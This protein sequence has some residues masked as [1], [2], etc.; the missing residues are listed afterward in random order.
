MP[1]SLL[2]LQA[3][4]SGTRRV[5]PVAQQSWP[6]KTQSL[7]LHPVPAARPGCRSPPGPGVSICETV[8]PDCGHTP[9]PQLRHEH[10]R[11]RQRVPPETRLFSLCLLSRGLRSG[12]KKR[13]RARCAAP[14]PGP[15][16][17]R[18]RL[19]PCSA[20]AAACR[21]G[22]G[23]SA[24]PDRPS[25]SFG[26]FWGGRR[27][28]E[29]LTKSTCPCPRAGTGLAPAG[30]VPAHRPRPRPPLGHREFLSPALCLLRVA[31][32][33]L[34]RTTSHPE[35]WRAETLTPPLRQRA[36]ALCLCS[37]RASTD[38][39]LSL[40]GQRDA[41]GPGKSPARSLTHSLAGLPPGPSDSPTRAPPKSLGP[42]LQKCLS[43]CFH[44]P[45]PSSTP[46]PWP[47][48]ACLKS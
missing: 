20:W 23:T 27:P 48:K 47:R 34:G 26:P 16:L 28:R 39:A 31:G 7:A 43:G 42:L 29:G 41:P 33:P 4:V 1:A 6:L 2:V 19:Q 36:P 12:A 24:A 10:P 40:S 44:Q 22:L 46:G 21:T 25:V 9:R 35:P 37:G 45:L 8:V 14:Q 5:R 32:P 13:S 38:P 3:E 15:A 11:G 17:P 30:L 18:G